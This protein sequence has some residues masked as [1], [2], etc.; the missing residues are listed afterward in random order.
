LD[1]RGRKAFREFKELRDHKDHKEFKEL[2]G[3]KD[4]KEFKEFKVLKAKRATLDRRALRDLLVPRVIL[5]VESSPNSRLERQ[6][7]LLQGPKQLLSCN[8]KET[9]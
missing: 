7:L 5:L 9:V 1:H 3:H 4:H 6:L 8:N 2:R